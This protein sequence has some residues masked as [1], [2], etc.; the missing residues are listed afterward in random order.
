MLLGLTV[1]DL[2]RS[3]AH[4]KDGRFRCIICD[5]S[6]RRKDHTRRHMR[7]IHLS[8]S[9]DYQCPPCKKFMKNRDAMYNHVRLVH[10]GGNV[11]NQIA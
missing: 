5:A 11:I 3:S 9:E 6:F 4:F 7:N 10:R 2:M 1:D 8:S